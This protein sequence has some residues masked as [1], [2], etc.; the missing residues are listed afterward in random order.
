MHANQQLIMASIQRFDRR[1]R[2]IEKNIENL[3]NFV[4]NNRKTSDE[5][6][7]STPDFFSYPS[8][9]GVY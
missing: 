5:F 9:G 6:V 7:F 3:A 8:Q 4:N 1:L 2:L